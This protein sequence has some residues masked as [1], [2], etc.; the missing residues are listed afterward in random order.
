VEDPADPSRPEHQRLRP[1]LD[2]VRGF[3]VAVVVAYHLGYLQ[4]GF[5]GVDVF[6]VLSGYLIT[7]LAIGEVRTTGGLSL[8][9]FWGRRWRRLMPASFVMVT[10]VVTTAVVTGWPR[11]QLDELAGGSFSTLTWW[12]NWYQ[13]GGASYWAAGESLFRHAWSLSIEEQFYVLWPVVLVAAI[14]VAHRLG[15]PVVATVGAVAA[16]GA[17]ASGAWQVILADRLP[18]GDLSRVYV[19]TDT[20]AVAPLLGCALACV[21]AAAGDRGVRLRRVLGWVGAAV[22]VV[23]CVTAEVASPDLYRQGRLL[24]A[25]AAAGLLVLS[26]GVAEHGDRDPVARAV[27]TSPARYLGRRSYGIYLW[28]WPL[29]VLLVFWWPGTD[30]WLV[31]AV[32]VAG[33]LALAELSHRWLEDPLRHRAGWAARPVI[34]RPAWTVLIVAGFGAVA[35]AAV[36]AVPPPE[37]QQVDTATSASEA[38]RTE[39][40]APAGVDTGDGVVDVMLTGDSTSWTVGYYLPRP[41]RWPEGIGA[42]DSRAL[43]GCGLLAVEGWQYP[44]PAGSDV[45]VEPGDGACEQQAEAE[46][47]G[48]AAGPDAVLLFPGAWEWTEAK[49]P[50]A[51]GGEGRVVEA[52]SDEMADVLA[53]VLADRIDAANEAGARFVMVAWSCPGPGAA[54]VRSDD[55]FIAWI[56]GVLVDAVDDAVARGGDAEMLWPTDEVCVDADPAGDATAAKDQAM[57]GEV[58]VIDVAGGEWIWNAWLGPALTDR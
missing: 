46:R 38:L 22:L 39:V 57:G 37:H 8:R 20:R 4:G 31:A 30:R 54:D 13:L 58:H 5:L 45:F 26:A 11:D 2:G 14:A 24:L 56:N 28:S 52:Q 55:D 17:V 21:V 40:T 15:R 6:F 51:N 32:V 35:A 43:I 12:N 10:V 19:G 16:V 49:D 48:L 42:I 50:A 27:T 1:G 44:Q 9:G 53:G 7:G 3:A 33:S 18:D 41:E 23:M 25:T 47:L 34:R 29:Q 36:L